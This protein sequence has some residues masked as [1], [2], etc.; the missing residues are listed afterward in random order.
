MHTVSK[1]GVLAVALLLGGCAANDPYQRTKAGA[2]LGALAGAAA[3]YAINDGKGAA[4]GAAIGALAG[5]AAGN[6]MDRQQAAFE[7]A[8]A[9]ERA[10]YNLELQRLQSGALKLNIPSEVSFGVDQSQISP[11]FIPILEKVAGLLNEY[12]QTLVTVIGHTDSTGAEAYNQQLSLRR[13][14]SVASV[15]ASRGVAPNRITAVGQGESQP[16]ADN[17][18]AAGRA[19]NRRVE[20]I[21]QPYEGGNYGQAPQQG[22]PQ[23]Q[24]GY[25]QQ[26]TGYPQQ[27]TGYPQQATGYPQQATGYPQQGGYQQPTGGYSQGYVAPGTAQSF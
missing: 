10:Q 15:L 25:P 6:Y 8:L 23:Q 22:Y 13:A 2:G 14:E 9:Q 20:I 12:N 18:T 24:Q 5:G 21:M 1:L 17:S 16:R 19:M 11:E 4:I 26:A 7:Q 27:A 3:G